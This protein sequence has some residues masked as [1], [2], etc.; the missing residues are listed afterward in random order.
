MSKPNTTIPKLVKNYFYIIYYLIHNSFY[1]ENNMVDNKELTNDYN[2][3]IEKYFSFIKK[4]QVLYIPILKAKFVEH[5]KIILKKQENKE[6]LTE[7]EQRDLTQYEIEAKNFNEFYEKRLV[8][9]HDSYNIVKELMDKNNYYLDIINN[10]NETD[11]EKIH[12]IKSFVSQIP[13]ILNGNNEDD[14]D[15]KN[16]FNNL[17]ESI[18]FL[19]TY[20][21]EDFSHMFLDAYY[22]N[23][24]IL[25]KNTKGCK[26]HF[27]FYHFNLDL[28]TH[29][30]RA[31]NFL[32]IF[33]I[34]IKEKINN[35]LKEQ[36]DMEKKIK[37]NIIQMDK[38]IDIHNKDHKKTCIQY[39]DYAKN[40]FI[41]QDK[42]DHFQFNGKSIYNGH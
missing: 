38:N 41:P 13:L 6:N 14:I 8:D 4:S 28:L 31:H 11:K 32:G 24:S 20:S 25:Y 23:I 34:G 9:I 5:I 17:V 42:K 15:V 36:E 33:Q 26:K 27:N 1:M 7:D 30:C 35:F 18:N 12:F 3:I 16:I 19:K 21:F 40:H 22:E 29:I 10:F 39:G 37:T 2:H